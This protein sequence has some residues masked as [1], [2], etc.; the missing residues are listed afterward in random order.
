MTAV[1]TIMMAQ[2]S[3]TSVNDGVTWSKDLE[4]VTVTRM[5]RLVKAD[6]DKMTYDVK[7][8]ADAVIMKP[9]TIMPVQALQLR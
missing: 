3:N 2:E 7:N 6:A 4:G 9:S 1:A 5:R 8:D